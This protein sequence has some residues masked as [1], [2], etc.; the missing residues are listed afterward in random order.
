M[1]V[2]IFL[3]IFAAKSQ[4][5][6]NIDFDK[7]TELRNE[8]HA[9][10]DGII[11]FIEDNGEYLTIGIP[12]F[13][14]IKVEQCMRVQMKLHSMS[15][16]TGLLID[17]HIVMEYMDEQTGEIKEV[18]V[19]RAFEAKAFGDIKYAKDSLKFILHVL[20]LYSNNNNNNTTM[21]KVE[22]FK[23]GALVSTVRLNGEK[24][25]GIYEHGYDNGQECCVS[26]VEGK[27][28]CVKLKST[29]EANEEE[30]KIIQETI[31]KPRR[32]AEKAR[33]KALEAAEQEEEELTEEDLEEAVAEPTQEELEE[34]FEASETTEE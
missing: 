17:K 26:G 23:K 29:K 5:S 14:H 28:Y 19:S 10:F 32:E 4:T 18:L 22:K 13:D 6:M 24:L 11:A 2:S 12:I 7:L 9:I 27:K 20:N 21:A 8:W 15:I 25:L 33:K 31:I 3:C 34:A 30:S 16:R 1:V